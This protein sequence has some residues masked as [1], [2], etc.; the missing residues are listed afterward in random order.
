MLRSASWINFAYLSEICNFAFENY[1][2]PQCLPKFQIPPRPTFLARRRLDLTAMA[3]PPPL[4]NTLNVNMLCKQRNGGLFESKAA[5]ITM[6]S[7]YTVHTSTINHGLSLR[8]SP[9]AY[10][11][12]FIKLCFS[13]LYTNSN[14]V[15]PF[16]ALPGSTRLSRA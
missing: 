8:H 2:Y 1:L 3:T 4:R 14:S 13:T 9:R 5:L 11:P 10:P 12:H 6:H 16:H 7:V 15:G